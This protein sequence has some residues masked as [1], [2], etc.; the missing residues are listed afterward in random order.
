MNK[1]PEMGICGSKP[2]QDVAVDE[3]PAKQEEAA[4]QPKPESAPDTKPEVTA[5]PETKAE[6]VDEPVKKAESTAAPKSENDDQEAFQ[7]VS[8]VIS[9]AVD[10]AEVDPEQVALNLVNAVIEEANAAVLAEETAALAASAVE[11]AINMAES[12][13]AADEIVSDIM[14]E[15]EASAEAETV[16][17][18]GIVTTLGFKHTHI[19]THANTSR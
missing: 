7:L 3:P 4:T 9:S 16:V 13:Q 19:H 12:I 11:E 14:M 18:A 15:A 6:P 2:H 10:A 17:N 5:A 1:N 8:D